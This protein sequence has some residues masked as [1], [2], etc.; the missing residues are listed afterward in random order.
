MDGNMLKHLSE[1]LK[2]TVEKRGKKP[3]AHER[4]YVAPTGLGLQEP[5]LNSPFFSSEGAETYYP[6]RSIKPGGSGE[7]TPLSD[8]SGS[9]P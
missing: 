9:Q 1:T 3:D 7:F 2:E 4:D 8:L 6:P 5:P